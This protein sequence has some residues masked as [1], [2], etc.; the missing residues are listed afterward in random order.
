M[1]ICIAIPVRMNS[2]RLPGKPLY[3]FG[4]VTLI[5]RCYQQALKTGIKVFVIT[6]SQE[7]KD[8]IGSDA[9]IVSGDIRNGTERLSKAARQGL[10]NRYNQIIYVQ[11]DQPWFDPE[12]IE[13]IKKSISKDPLGQFDIRHLY[14]DLLP[15]EKDNPNVVKIVHSRGLMKWMSRQFNYGSRVIGIYSFSLSFLLRHNDLEVLEAEAA[16]NCEQLRWLEHG[17]SVKVIPV[18]APNSFVDINTQSDIEKWRM[19]N[20]L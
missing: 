20:S 5:E 3:D 10:F 9:H 15:G 2:S 1:S 13:Q 7:I 18:T 6:D 8:L 11:G 12:W 17:Y 4:G 19:Y 16:E 14:T